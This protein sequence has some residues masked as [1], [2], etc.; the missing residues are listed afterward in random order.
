MPDGEFFLPIVGKLD[1]RNFSPLEVVLFVLVQNFTAL[2]HVGVAEP[3]VDPFEWEAVVVVLLEQLFFVK[4]KPQVFI[5]LVKLY[6]HHL[7]SY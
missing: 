2:G 3:L 4:G 6:F 7:S 5:V 1:V